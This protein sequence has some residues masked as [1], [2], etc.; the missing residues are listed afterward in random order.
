MAARDCEWDALPG[1][2]VENIA[3]YLDKLMD[4]IS[5]SLTCVTAHLHWQR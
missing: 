2:V 4:L 1:L 3:C 5:M